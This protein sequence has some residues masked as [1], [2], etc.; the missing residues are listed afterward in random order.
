MWDRCRAEFM[1]PTPRVGAIFGILHMLSNVKMAL[2]ERL[3]TFV[4]TQANW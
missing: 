1:G 4:L 3:L 2:P